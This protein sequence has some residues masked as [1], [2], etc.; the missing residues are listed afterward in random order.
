MEM[1]KCA[2]G[3]YYRLTRRLDNAK[4]A[5]LPRCSYP[6]RGRILPSVA[7]S[8]SRKTAA[9]EE[10]VRSAH[11]GPAPGP[12]SKNIPGRVHVPV[13]RLTTIGTL[14]LSYSKVSW[15]AGTR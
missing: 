2:G 14:P 7:R 13:V 9:T 5:V 11:G 8:I 1:D 10:R 15:T 3:G 6:H 12:D 4:A